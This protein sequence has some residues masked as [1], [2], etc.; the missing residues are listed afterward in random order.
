MGSKELTG[1]IAVIKPNAC[2]GAAYKTACVSCFNVNAVVY[3]ALTYNGRMLNFGIAPMVYLSDNTAHKGILGADVFTYHRGI[4]NA[5]A[6]DRGIVTD[7]GEKSSV[8]AFNVIENTRYN[9]TVTVEGAAEVRTACEPVFGIFGP[10]CLRVIVNF[11]ICGELIEFSC[12]RSGS[13]K[14]SKLLRG[15]DKVRVGFGSAS[16]RKLG[17][18]FARPCATLNALINK[19]EFNLLYYLRMGRFACLYGPDVFPVEFGHIFLSGIAGHLSLG[20]NL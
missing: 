11:Y 17:S 3:E 7:G 4:Y 6:L 20:E 9:V 12:G 15:F 19:G 16:A 14:Q 13:Y 10:I 2:G 18:K 5:D 8:S 1:S